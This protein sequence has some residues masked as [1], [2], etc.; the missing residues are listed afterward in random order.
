M[1]S[2]ISLNR[3]RITEVVL[4]DHTEEEVTILFSDIRDYTTL[5]ETMTPEENFKFVNAFHGRMGPVIRKHEGFV[6]Q[7][8][9]DAIMAILPKSPENALESCYRH[10]KSPEK[11]ITSNAKPKNAYPSRWA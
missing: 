1:S 7:Y 5:S 11:N 9:G 2:C 10:A 6:N 3:E 4:G 8:L